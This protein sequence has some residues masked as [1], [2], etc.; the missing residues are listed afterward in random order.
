[1][2]IVMQKDQMED[3]TERAEQIRRERKPGTKIW[4]DYFMEIF[5]FYRVENGDGADDE[6]RE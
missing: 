2:A 5:G 1:M 4:P 6:L 3:L